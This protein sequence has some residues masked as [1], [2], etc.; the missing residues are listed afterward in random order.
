MNIPKDVKEMGKDAVGITSMHL[1]EMKAHYC[2]GGL[3]DG[4]CKKFLYNV[5]NARLEPI[6]TRREE[7]QKDIPA[8]YEMLRRGCE[9]ARKVAQQTMD[10]VRSAMKIDYFNDAELIKEQAKKYN[11]K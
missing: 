5:L 8:I 4:T 11:G 2:K 1:D 6:R 7:L 10:E 9:E 3:G